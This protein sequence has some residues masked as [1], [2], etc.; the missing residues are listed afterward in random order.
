MGSDSCQ[1]IDYCGL[2]D[3]ILGLIYN[4]H[5]KAGLLHISYI[6]KEDISSEKR[7]RDKRTYYVKLLHISLLGVL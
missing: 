5:K 3:S 4:Q 2:S 1:I 6:K 7:R